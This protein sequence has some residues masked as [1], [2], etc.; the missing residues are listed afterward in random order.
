MQKIISTQIVPSLNKCFQNIPEF[1]FQVSPSDHAFANCYYGG[2]ADKKVPGTFFLN[3]NFKKMHKYGDLSLSL[4]EAMPGHH[5]QGIYCLQRKELPF[6]RRVMDGGHYSEAPSRFPTHCAYLEGWGLYAETLG[7]ELGLF[8]DPLDL[9]GKLRAEMM[10]AV[11]LVVD[12]GMHAFGWSIEE[13]EKYFK[14]KM[15]LDPLSNV[16]PEIYRY[17][18]WPGQA[19]SYKIGEM[20]IW[21]LRKKTE[22]ALGDT[23]DLKQFHEVILSCGYIPLTILEK[24]V[25]RYILQQKCC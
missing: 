16:A 17:V 9:Y 21:E 5:L 1:P 13:A 8:N 7:I 19:C 22:N 3:C 25:D 18:T 6:F 20:K 10:R 23:F 2:T 4:H 15:R 12:T 24:L 11:R 14:Q